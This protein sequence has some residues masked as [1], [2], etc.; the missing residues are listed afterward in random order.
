MGVIKGIDAIGPH[1]EGGVLTKVTSEP[2]WEEVNGGGLPSPSEVKRLGPL[3]TGNINGRNSD[4]LKVAFPASIIGLDGYDPAALFAEH[5]SGVGGIWSGL[6]EVSNQGTDSTSHMTFG[7]SPDLRNVD[8]ESLNIPNPFVPDISAGQAV[9]ADYADA[10]HEK[11]DGK[12]DSYPQRLTSA[13]GA[14]VTHA[15]TGVD[16]SDGGI[17]PTESKS[18]IGDWLS[19]TLGKWTAV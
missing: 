16:G 14:E 4:L 17:N 9:A 7:E 10:F 6:A 1:A 15:G 5:M 8:I 13:N 2:K 3:G 18:S 11:Y 19:P 12:Q